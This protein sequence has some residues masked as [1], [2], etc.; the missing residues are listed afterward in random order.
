MQKPRPLFDAS[1]LFLFHFLPIKSVSRPGEKPHK[2]QLDKV[3]IEEKELCPLVSLHPG[4]GLHRS[5]RVCG[6]FR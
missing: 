5:S 1:F 3:G 4:V 2:E 6:R